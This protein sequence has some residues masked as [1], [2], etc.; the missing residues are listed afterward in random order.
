MVHS[1]SVNLM[2]S[3]FLVAG[4]TIPFAYTKLDFKNPFFAK[5]FQD[6]IHQ[7]HLHPSITEKWKN[8]QLGYDQ[9]QNKLLYYRNGHYPLHTI[10]DLNQ[11]K[12]I[13]LHEHSHFKKMGKSKHEVVDYVGVKIQFMDSKLPAKMLEI[14][15]EKL[16]PALTAERS[17]ATKWLSILQNR[18]N[19]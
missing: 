1:E 9:E 5:T 12:N 14:Y 17:I 2:V 8:H 18:I 19:S 3:F 10:I 13:S 4:I 6:F 11:V 15:D 7:N 16:V